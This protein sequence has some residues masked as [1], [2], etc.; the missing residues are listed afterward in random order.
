MYFFFFFPTGTDSKPGHPPVGTALLIATMVGIFSL[1]H[2]RP[3]LYG[4]LLGATFFPSHPT[5][6][7]AF[8]SIFLHGSWAHL[9]GNMLYLW[10]FGR[11]FEGRLGLGALAVVLLGGGVLSCWAQAALT[12]PDSRAYHLPLVGASG[13]IAALLGAT[14]LRFSFQRV[15][16][17]YFLFALLGGIAR[18]GVVGVPSVLACGFWFAFQIVHG[19][20]AWGHGAATVAYAA[21]AG[22]FVAGL[23]LGV[24]AGYPAQAR[25]ER[26]RERGRRQFEKGNWFAAAGELTSHLALSPDDHEAREM[27]ARCFLLLGQIGEA[28]GDYLVAFRDARRRHDVDRVA[29]LYSEMRR[30]GV[31]T[32][33]QMP[34]LLRLAFDLQ[35]GGHANEAAIAFEE[36]ASRFPA[37]PEAEL[38]MVRR[39]ELLWCN[40]GRIEDAL[41]AY[42]NVLAAHPQ[43]EWRH[44]AEGRVRAMRALAG[45][46]VV[47]SRR[48]SRSA[49]V[50]SATP[51]RSSS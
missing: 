28:A 40:L 22:G 48:D 14:M 30:Y 1:S 2:L 25:R 12:P 3:E 42:E 41:H 36:L 7:G 5:W 11:Q 26:H 32:N 39:A 34:A 4:A 10:I 31:G 9:A 15:R 20:V 46:R 47:S 8:L 49:R 38:A 18:G 37:G 50:P 44:F 45:A 43:G 35:R 6:P 13:G 21:H 33:L 19:L 29:R 16:V 17:L 27:R 23:G 51:P 24:L